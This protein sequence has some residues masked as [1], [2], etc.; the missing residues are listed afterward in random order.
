MS[1]PQ[2]EVGEIYQVVGLKAEDEVDLYNA[3]TT[4]ATA[5]T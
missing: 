5:E 1:T 3:S 4:I 2:A